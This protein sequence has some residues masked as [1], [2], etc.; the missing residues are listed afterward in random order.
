MACRALE[1]AHTQA[2]LKLLHRIGDGRA[3]QAG[4]FGGKRETA[5][6]HDAAKHPHGIESVHLFVRFFRIV[7]TKNA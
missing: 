6:F 7:M 4:V 5:A 1:Q 3:R 2:S